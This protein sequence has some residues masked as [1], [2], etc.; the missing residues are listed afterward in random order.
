MRSMLLQRKRK[1]H[2]ESPITDSPV[3]ND[4]A[5]HVAEVRARLILYTSMM[6][7]GWCGSTGH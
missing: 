3:I 6:D 4:P 5:E 7:S 1:D 2:P